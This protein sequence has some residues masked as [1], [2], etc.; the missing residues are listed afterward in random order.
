[1]CLRQAAGFTRHKQASSSTWASHHRPRQ[2]QGSFIT[3]LSR[4]RPT[5]PYDFLF[6]MGGLTYGTYGAGTALVI[7]GLCMWMQELGRRD[8]TEY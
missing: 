7:I 1:M 8:D 3:F 5:R 4:T 6:T 2:A